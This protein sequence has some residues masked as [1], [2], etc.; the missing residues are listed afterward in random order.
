MSFRNKDGA[1]EC[2]LVSAVRGFIDD[3]IFHEV[4]LVVVVVVVVLLD[5]RTQWFST[6]PA[7]V[8][9]NLRPRTSVLDI[10]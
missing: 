2:V 4:K 5:V 6:R 7:H 1:L 8:P 10:C 3:V 9:M